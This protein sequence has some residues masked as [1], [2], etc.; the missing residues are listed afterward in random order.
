MMA[1]DTRT[2]LLLREWRL[3]GGMIGEAALLPST[4][5]NY[6]ELQHFGLSSSFSR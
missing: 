1:G 3:R 4:L 5:E 6:R 2:I